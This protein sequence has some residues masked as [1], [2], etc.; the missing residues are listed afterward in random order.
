MDAAESDRTIKGSLLYGH[1]EQVL[2]RE[3]AYEKLKAVVP[4]A[5]TAGDGAAARGGNGKE[6]QDEG[7]LMGNLSSILFG[8]TDRVEAARRPGADGGQDDHPHHGLPGEPATVRGVLGSPAGPAGAAEGAAAGRV[9]RWPVSGPAF[10]ARTLLQFARPVSRDQR[11]L[12]AR[13]Q[14]GRKARRLIAMALR[15]LASSSIWAR[16]AI[17]ASPS[18]VAPS[19]SAARWCSPTASPRLGEMR[20]HRLVATV[21][22]RRQC[23]IP[24]LPSVAVRCGL[25]QFAS[26]IGRPAMM[27]EYRFMQGVRASVVLCSSRPS[28]G[29]AARSRVRQHADQPWRVAGEGG[30]ARCG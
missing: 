29:Q 7:G 1:Y 2:D 16:G 28:L 26:G 27:A 5:Q 8:R 23:R 4:E 25:F 12:A 6:S 3:S 22:Q 14:F 24:S 21:L 10:R 13:R 15:G 30:V 18:N 11:Q 9:P 20:G 17:P 19:G